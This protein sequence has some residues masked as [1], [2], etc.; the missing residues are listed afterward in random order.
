MASRPPFPPKPGVPSGRAL[1][2]LPA[3]P[4]RAAPIVP[5]RSDGGI[6]R[7]GGVSKV[8]DLGGGGASQ[9]W[10]VITSS[11]RALTV[12]EEAPSQA[13]V[14]K[15]ND[16]K[17]VGQRFQHMQPTAVL[18]S[19]AMQAAQVRGINSVM[20]VV[21]STATMETVDA[22]EMKILETFSGCPASLK[23]A[24]ASARSGAK[25]LL[26]M[27][28]DPKFT[29]SANKSVPTDKTQAGDGIMTAEDQK[30]AKELF[31][32]LRAN[33]KAWQ[34]LGH[35]TIADHLVG[36]GDRLNLMDGDVKVQN[37]GNLIFSKNA[38]G[39]ITHALGYDA[40]NP[41]AGLAKNIYGTDIER[42][43]DEYGAFIRDKS[44]FPDI[45]KQI[46]A[47]INIKRMAPLKLQPFG[48]R[49]IFALGTGLAQGWDKYAN[50]IADRALR[51]QG[52]PSGLMAR[53]VWM[54][55]V[56]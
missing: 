39:Q 40:I 54:G 35:V 49:E 32:G 47:D 12:K 3:V 30:K 25:M 38:Q 29:T 7:I 8:E 34:T 1:P 44:K 52:V 50:L 13:N 22:A 21:S 10:K 19:P 17:P 36:N 2:P 42:W 28:F 14:A 11:N 18:N 37:Y 9:I 33:D 27:N 46:I 45:A 26:K 4:Q 51:G 23:G 31:E 41:F 55:W 24:I 16:A 5:P 53:A 43:A 15:F 48:P 20:G 56:R 6:P